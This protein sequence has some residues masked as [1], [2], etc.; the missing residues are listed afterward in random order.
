MDSESDESK[1]SVITYKRL[2]QLLIAKDAKLDEVLA[3][4]RAER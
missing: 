4:L 2:E 1:E 3:E